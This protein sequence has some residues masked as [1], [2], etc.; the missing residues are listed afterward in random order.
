MAHADGDVATRRLRR[1]QQRLAETPLARAARERERRAERA[2]NSAA[3]RSVAEPA[4]E[5][6]A[7]VPARRDAAP[8]AQRALRAAA[9]RL[10]AVDQEAD[11]ELPL[12]HASR[13]TPYRPRMR[14]GFDVSPLHRPHP[15]GVVRATRGLVAALERRGASRSCAS[16]RPRARAPALAAGRPAARLARSSARPDPL[17][18]LGLPLVARGRARA[19]DPRAALAARRGRERGPPPPRLGRA[20]PA[21]RRA[22]GRGD[23]IRRARP[24]RRVPARARAR[25]RRPVGRR[26]DLPA[27]RRRA[28]RRATTT[29]C[30]P[31]AGARRS[32]PRTPRR[33]GLVGS[34]RGRASGPRS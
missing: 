13:A 19:D 17:A 4:R 2:S 8:A 12:L 14:I 10:P 24:R 5:A 15:P 30:S 33:T 3:S 29:C 31:A 11:A 27:R 22:R 6:R 1:G 26:P 23:R 16:R 20:R 9:V 18:R 7:R 28:P 34:V 25:A 21:A 32:A